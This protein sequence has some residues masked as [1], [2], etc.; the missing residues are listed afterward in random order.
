[1]VSSITLA[2]S[3]LTF[4][5]PVPAQADGETAADIT[6]L[7]KYIAANMTERDTS[8]TIHYSG[9]Q[10]QATSDLKNIFL[11]SAASDDYLN[12]AWKQMRYTCSGNSSGQLDISFT[13]DYHTTKEEEEFIDLTVK[14]LVKK[15]IT[16]KMD[17][18]AKE[19]AIHNW[20][21]KNVKYDYSLKQITAYTAF[22][23]NRT[24]CMGYSML[25][26]KMLNEAGVECK[27]ITGYYPEGYHAWNMIKINSK[28]YHLDATYDWA[29][30]ATTPQNKTDAEMLKA[31]YTWDKALTDSFAKEENNK[32]V[33][34]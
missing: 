30:A 24:T 8:F 6:E 27:V 25:M 23:S 29:I 34:K 7:K 26:K 10:S 22:T 33:K 12:L 3:F 18:F 15:L 31:N 11:Q 16:P 5:C 28:W 19:T 2:L 20:I 13:L 32:E 1:M 21:V 14:E 9:N 17:D 4:G